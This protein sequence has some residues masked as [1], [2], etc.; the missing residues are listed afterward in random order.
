MDDFFFFYLWN[1]Q[2]SKMLLLGHEENVAEA[3]QAV[4]KG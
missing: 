4:T 1:P 2:I 3:D